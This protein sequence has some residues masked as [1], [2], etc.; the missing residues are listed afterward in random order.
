M[1]QTTAHALAGPLAG[2]TFGRERDP[3]AVL[4]HRAGNKTDDAPTAKLEIAGNWS[5]E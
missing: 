5:I 2:Q 1:V 4:R 3:P